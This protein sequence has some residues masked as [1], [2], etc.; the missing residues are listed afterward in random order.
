MFKLLF[1]TFAMITLPLGTYW[2]TLNYIFEGILRSH[3]HFPCP[4]S[5]GQTLMVGYNYTK[6]GVTAIAIAHMVLFAY[7][8]V[9]IK[10][11]S[12]DKQVKKQQ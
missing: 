5:G 7:I 2:F 6:A 10:E 11:D 9:A 1:F 8:Y 12:E 3:V 4:F